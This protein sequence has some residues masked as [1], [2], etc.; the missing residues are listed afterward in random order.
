MLR[1]RVACALLRRVFDTQFLMDGK[2]FTEFGS[3]FDENDTVS[4]CPVS[5]PS[6]TALSIV[7]SCHL[8][9]GNF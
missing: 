2:L 6:A 7:R 8:P 4:S 1:K 3:P 9:F 5:Y